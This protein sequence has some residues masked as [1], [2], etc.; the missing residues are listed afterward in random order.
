MDAEIGMKRIIRSNNEEKWQE[1]TKYR[2]ERES[3]TRNKGS[4]IQINLQEQQSVEVAI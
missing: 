3:M 4:K 1:K 2:E